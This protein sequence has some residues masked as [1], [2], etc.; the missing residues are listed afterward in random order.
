M[1]KCTSQDATNNG[2]KL[3]EEKVESFENRLC[4]QDDIN[5]FL[6]VKNSYTDYE[7]RESF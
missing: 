1:R 3:P 4:P 5:K 7:E 2:F 6:K